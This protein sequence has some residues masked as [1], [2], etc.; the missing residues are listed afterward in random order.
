MGKH[1]NIILAD[2]STR[3]IL[4]SIKHIDE[5][6]SRHREILPGVTYTPPPHPAKLH[7]LK[8][9]YETFVTFFENNSE[10]DWRCLFNQVDGLS[11]TLA[12]ELLFRTDKPNC[13]E[14]LW[15]AYKRD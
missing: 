15:A 4:Q 9:D 6:L 1:S 5:T 2:E 7:P 13:A 11:P 8:L 10:V 3:K 14:K 12:K